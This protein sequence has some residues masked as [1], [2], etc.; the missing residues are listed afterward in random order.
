MLLTAVGAKSGRGVG[1]AEIETIR[2]MSMLVTLIVCFPASKD[3]TPLYAVRVNL[4]FEYLVTSLLVAV[5]GSVW[6]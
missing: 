2:V 1:E 3:D 5:L 6:Y 4:I